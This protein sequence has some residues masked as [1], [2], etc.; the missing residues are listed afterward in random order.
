MEQGPEEADM[1]VKP[2]ALQSHICEVEEILM[3]I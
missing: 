2:V 1:T 3:V